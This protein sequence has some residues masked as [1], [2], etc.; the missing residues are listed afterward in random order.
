MIKKRRSS[1][2][3]G[4]VPQKFPKLGTRSGY[5]S[6]IHADRSRPPR[7]RL[8]FPAPHRRDNFRRHPHTHTGVTCLK[9]G[10]P[11]CHLFGGEKTQQV[12]TRSRSRAYHDVAARAL[13]AFSTKTTKGQPP[14]FIL[15]S[16]WHFA[17][18]LAIQL[19]DSFLGGGVQASASVAEPCEPGP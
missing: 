2:P 14:F 18:F 3:R 5:A 15:F 4:K 19:R 12:S 16:H 13:P 10:H 1:P 9:F 7:T 17:V 8:C 11:D 6:W